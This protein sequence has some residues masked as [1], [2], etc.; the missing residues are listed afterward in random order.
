MHGTGFNLVDNFES[1]Q[2]DIVQNFWR[3]TV[4]ET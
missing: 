2:A 3:N 1:V 4:E